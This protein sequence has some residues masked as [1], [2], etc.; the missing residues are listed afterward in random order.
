MKLVKAE[1]GE[2]FPSGL[3]LLW[4]DCAG[5][6]CR[7]GEGADLYRQPAERKAADSGIR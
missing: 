6:V 5:A 3:C 4:G 2:I 1:S 7:L